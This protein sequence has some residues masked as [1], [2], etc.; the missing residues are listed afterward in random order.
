MTPIRLC[1]NTQTPLVRF[2]PGYSK[3]T[4]ETGP[5]SLS[6]LT[7]DRD[8]Q[9]TPGGVTRMV[10]PLLKR[11]LVNGVIQSPHWVTLNPVG[12]EEIVADGIIFSHIKMQ[13]K[14][15]KGY[16]HIKEDMWKTIHGIVKGLRP[17][18][19]PLWEKEYA[20]YTYYNRLS[21]ERLVALDKEVDFDVFYIHDFQ[22]LPVGHM[23]GS[24]KPKVF[25]WHIP[26]DD[27]VIPADWKP[28]LLKYFS[29]YDLVL[30]SCKK[31]L[32]ALRKFGFTGNVQYIFPYINQ[33]DYSKPTP[34]ELE[35]FC[36]RFGIREKD[37]VLL[38]VARMDPMKGQ[39]L[40][41]RAFAR[42]AKSI[43]DLKL[44]LAG[45]GSF[46]S[47]SHG[48]GLSK[49]ADWLDKLRHL[50]KRLKLEDRV[51]FTGHINQRELQA[52]YER[53]EMTLLPSLM[54]GFGLVVIE[55]WLYKKP[56][57][58]SSRSGVADIIIDGDNGYLADPNDID[59][60]AKRIVALLKD[61][62]LASRL[63]EGGHES[64]K[65]CTLD[66]GIK[67]EAE[68]L[69]GLI[70]GKTVKGDKDAI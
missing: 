4:E 30:V 53:C 49:G 57:V 19:W 15:M 68:M 61:P 40:A 16:G 5:P 35:A 11:M 33:S 58:V 14:V 55:S 67:N 59:E 23:L 6:D 34:G 39:D 60:F 12:P 25:R 29:A 3:S 27:S 18:A 45:N 47:S 70:S 43:P 32:D 20:D 26:F 10:F 46:S 66:E 24:L 7:E 42:A 8:Y 17:H 48:I 50:V 21:S 51:I 63:G 36:T 52:A 22:Q 38:V 44:V 1:V 9:F 65:K 37:R 69:R 2:N 62:K 56:A 54:E 28:F 64:S 13:D 31:Y 41:I